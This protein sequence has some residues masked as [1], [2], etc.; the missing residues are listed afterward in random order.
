[1]VLGSADRVVGRL[2][3]V[4]S[5]RAR[6]GSDLDVAGRRLRQH[7]VRSS[8]AALAVAVG[9]CVVTMLGVASG[10]A[11]AAVDGY[12]A[13]ATGVSQGIAGIVFAGAAMISLTALTS[14]LGVVTTISYGLR[15]RHREIALLRVLGQTPRHTRRMIRAEAGLLSAGG[16]V[17]GLACGVG[18]GWFGA[19][20]LLSRPTHS[21]V[22]VPVLPLTLLLAVALGAAALTWVASAWPAREVLRRPAIRAYLEA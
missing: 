3:G 5:R 16:V 18:Y 1:A 10:T 8:R 22:L 19:Q 13:A 4:L 17:L 21:L 14:A 6:P 11:F 12:F 15:L 2:V 9:V 7:G 20:V